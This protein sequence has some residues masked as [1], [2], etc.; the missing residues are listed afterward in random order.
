M[1][2]RFTSAE[3]GKGL[4]LFE[5][6]PPRLRI[7]APAMDTSDLVRKNALTLIG[8]LTNPE[9][10]RMKSMLPYFANKWELRGNVTG[11]DL[12]HGC[13]Q[14]RFDYDEDLKK[15]LENRPYQYSRWMLILEKWKP[16]ISPTFPSQIPFWISLRGLPLHYWKSELLRSIGEKLG[17]LD[18]F[19]LT[20]TAAKIRVDINGLNPITKEAIVEFEGGYKALVTL[21]YHKLDKHCTYCLKLTHEERE[22]PTNPRSALRLQK[23]KE[24]ERE[25]E[26][27]NHLKP[28][29]FTSSRDHA[30]NLPH[31]R[32]E[33]NSGT[34]SATRQSSHPQ[35][36]PRSNSHREH[37]RLPPRHNRGHPNPSPP[38]Q[39]QRRDSLRHSDSGSAR[40]GS[41]KD[42]P[43]EAHRRNRRSPR[44]QPTHHVWREKV[45]QRTETMEDNYSPSL[46]RSVPVGRN[47]E[48]DD[49]PTPPPRIQTEEEILQDLHDI[50]VR[51]IN[52][53]DPIESAARR[54]RV[55]EGDLQGLGGETAA[56]LYN[57]PS[58]QAHPLPEQLDYIPPTEAGQV[59]QMPFGN[60][61]AGDTLNPIGEPEME[62]VLTNNKR[63][64]GRPPTKNQISTSAGP[65]RRK[66][67]NQKSFPMMRI[68]PLSK[69]SYQRAS[70][71]THN[72][73]TR[74]NNRAITRQTQQQVEGRSSATPPPMPPNPAQNTANP[75]KSRDRADFR[76]PRSPLA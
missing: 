44:S 6:S 25:I 62:L 68:S 61:D 46:R 10:Q 69:I 52:C 51:Y 45:I 63:K 5:P 57:A 3:K 17:T 42:S 41:S 76:I 23:E 2:R 55:L 24:K 40:H 29:F 13:F 30:P 50:D 18:S 49:F 67:K 72:N 31:R 12:G 38:Y 73:G 35:T 54:K 71:S 60:I 19:E 56:F 7:R 66:T 15:V 74:H 21:E 20:S 48:Q 8:R 28:P 16:I 47:L 37:H 64:R 75:E 58:N 9:E 27:P 36:P 39:R 26:K 22:C 53:G 32:T 34:R 70:P 33:A 43:E 59:E 65:S 4:A 14:F 11:S 1:S